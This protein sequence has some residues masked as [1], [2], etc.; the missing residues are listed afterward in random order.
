MDELALVD[1]TQPKHRRFLANLPKTSLAKSMSPNKTM[2]GHST[3]YDSDAIFQL[4]KDNNMF[5]D[6]YG[7]SPGMGRVRHE[8]QQSTGYN[9]CMNKGTFATAFD[10]REYFEN[11]IRPQNKQNFEK[12][13]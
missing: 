12:G 6:K 8:T 2:R 13:I 11:N 7:V 4:T 10:P 3:V 5:N 9:L 1:Q